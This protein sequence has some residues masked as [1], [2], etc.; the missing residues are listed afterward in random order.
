[1]HSTCKTFA[2]IVTV[3][4]LLG[5]FEAPLTP[6][7]LFITGMWYKRNEQPLRCGSFYLGVGVG[8]IIGALSSFGLQF[9]V[10]K[11]FK[12][13]QVRLPPLDEFSNSDT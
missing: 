7:L 5:V 6:C 4:V 3:R 2:G 12:S 10:G 9:Y 1:M 13:W 11:A 8:T